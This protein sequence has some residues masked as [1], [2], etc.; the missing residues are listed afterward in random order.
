MPTPTQQASAKERE[1]P[2]IAIEYDLKDIKDILVKLSSEKVDKNKRVL[3][4]L[5]ASK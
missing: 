3:Q 5:Q 2:N 1:S 4:K